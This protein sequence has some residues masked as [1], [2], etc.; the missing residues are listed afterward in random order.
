MQPLQGVYVVM[1][2]P[3]TAQ[4]QVDY[5]GIRK[6]V[7]WWVR[8]GVHGLIPLGSTG[9]FASLEDADKEK[10]TD[11]VMEAVGGRIP[12]VV[13]A[14]AETTEKTIRNALYAE[15]SGAAGVLI[16]PPYYYIPSQEEIF[17]HYRLVSEAI[18]T[19]IM[20]YNNPFSSKVDIKA[21]TVARLARLPNVLY[22]KESCGDIKRITAI[23]EMTDDGITVFCGWEDMAYESFL[24]GARGWVCV[25]GNM[26][27]KASVDLFNLMVEQ[28][29]PAS[30]W[31]L[32]K[33]MLP[34]LR[35]LE[36]AGKTQ[37]LLKYALDR[38]GLC[39]GYSSS[40]KLPIEADDK[41]IV[42]GTL[43]EFYQI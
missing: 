37:K 25:I 39:G 8:E 1:V 15:R 24:M 33:R 6:N 21:E 18:H 43:K 40:P 35:Y 42:D 27:P 26:L 34:M 7:E 14:T 32:Y 19:P 3:F 10:L 29:D 11:T 20:I 28:E 22:I 13:G 16:L 17:H 4:G 9:E 36:Y 12:V 23:R 31:R 38:L 2:T 30:A 5:A 41:A